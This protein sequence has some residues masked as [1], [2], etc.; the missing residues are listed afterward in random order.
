MNEALSWLEQNA[1]GIPEPLRRRMADA[2]AGATGKSLPEA[3]A[4][5]AFICMRAALADPAADDAALNLLSA[6]ALITHACALGDT[7]FFSEEL[8][9]ATFEQLYNQMHD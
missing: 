5:G 1:A 8:D 9:Q 6:D 3:L 4:A 7:P 2:L